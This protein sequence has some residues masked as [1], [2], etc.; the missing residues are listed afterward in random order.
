MNCLNCDDWELCIINSCNIL[1]PLY[2]LTG[3][4][5]NVIFKKVNMH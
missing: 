4:M 1:V 3:K 2:I 5:I